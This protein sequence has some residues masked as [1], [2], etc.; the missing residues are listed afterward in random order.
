MN[1]I[2]ALI[3]SATAV[4]ATAVALFLLRQGQVDRRELRHE[5]A[6]EQATQV[7][8]WADWHR[9][10]EFVTFAR[11]QLPA[12]MVANSSAAAVFD[13]FVDFRTPIAGLPVRAAI[14]PVPPGETRLRVIE[15][16]G[17]LEDGWEPAALF[18]RVYFRD[19][20]GQRWI[21]DAMGRLRREDQVWGEDDFFKDGGVLLKNASESSP[22]PNDVKH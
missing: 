20:A 15:Y 14:G 22:R 21:R 7:T 4:V 11:P 2:A 6:R 8:A 16:E 3:S 5:K 10:D 19:S 13:V 18:P 1:D 9:E 12:V 17:Q